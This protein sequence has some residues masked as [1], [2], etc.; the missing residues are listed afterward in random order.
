MTAVFQRKLAKILHPR[1]KNGGV[2]L[3]ILSLGFMALIFVSWG[4]YLGYTQLVD[5]RETVRSLVADGIDQAILLP[6]SQN[7]AYFDEGL[8]GTDL[9]LEAANVAPTT[10]NALR[11]SVPGSTTPP[12]P[13]QG[14]SCPPGWNHGL[15]NHMEHQLQQF[16]PSINASCNAGTNGG[17]FEWDLPASYAANAHIAGPVTVDDIQ[18][19]SSNPSTITLFNQR[20]TLHSPVLAAEVWIPVKVSL[21]GPLHWSSVI[22]EAIIIPLTGRQTPTQFKNY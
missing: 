8:N 9:Q 17:G 18:V 12:C 4:T 10:E 3:V 7:G 13:T 20:Q 6:S 14:F 19:D 1:Q 15:C 22:K 2:S 5:T 21:L 16:L 11:Q